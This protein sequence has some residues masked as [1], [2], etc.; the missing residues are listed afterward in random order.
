MRKLSLIF[1]GSPVYIEESSKAR[2][3]IREEEELEKKLL[4]EQKSA[5]AKKRK[6]E[7][8]PSGGFLL[9]CKSDNTVRQ[10]F[11]MNADRSASRRRE[12]L[13]SEE[14]SLEYNQLAIME[15]EEDQ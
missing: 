11:D 14:Q 1:T 7:E 5:S 2:N 3:N 12:P 4:N 6:E 8:A 15:G 13:P 10:D 9:C